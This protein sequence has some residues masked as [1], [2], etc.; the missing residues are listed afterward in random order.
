MSKFHAFTKG[1]LRASMFDAI[2]STGRTWLQNAN[3]LDQ[4]EHLFYYGGHFGVRNWF[5]LYNKFEVNDEEN[6]PKTG[7]I[8]FVANHRSH[9]DPIFVSAAT[10][11]KIH[12]MS[13][14]ENFKEPIMQSIFKMWS[15]FPVV[16]GSGDSKA[17]QTALDYLKSGRCI[18]IFPEGTRSIDNKMG[19]LHNGAARMA[20]M[21]GATIMPCG[22]LGTYNVLKKGKTIPRP[23]KVTV[24][25]GTPIYTSEVKGQHDDW[26]LVRSFT[27]RI[28]EQIRKLIGEI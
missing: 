19:K 11:R 21:T 26:D 23:E 9:L 28:D 24:N 4:A 1:L 8:V 25:W 2:V 5:K 22:I 16:R 7:P 13:K 27:A 20:I 6:V 15:A 18:G 12:W 17:L 3:L 10:Y 14:L